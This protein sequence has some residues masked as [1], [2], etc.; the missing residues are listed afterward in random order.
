MIVQL[1]N[2]IAQHAPDL[3]KLLNDN[4]ALKAMTTA[5]DGKIYTVCDAPMFVNSMVVQNA[6]FIRQDWLDNLGLPVPVTLDDW[7]RVLTAFKNNDPTRT[8]RRDVVPYAGISRVGNLDNLMAFGSAF[9]LPV[10]D[11]EWWYDSSGRVFHV[12]SSP[13]YREF[14]TVMNQWYKDGLLD[15]E[16]NREEPNFQSLTSTNVVGAF[17]HLSERTTQYD[18]FVRSG[19][20]GTAKHILVPPPTAPNGANPQILKR[21]PTW[22]HYGITRDCKDPA[23]AMKWINFV[24][25]SDEGVLMNEYGV[26]GLSFTRGPDGKPRFTDFV[27]RNPNGLDPYNALRSLGACNTIL[28]RTPAQAYIDLNEGTDAIPFGQRLL[29]YR[30]EPFPEVMLSA[31][32]QRVVDRLQPDIKT[33]HDETRVKFLIGEIPLSNWD[34]YVQT[35]RSMGLDDVQ[36]VRQQQYNRGK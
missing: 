8:G 9:G 14:L 20:V 32:E 24:Y 21:P 22:S 11:T 26:E 17:V 23:L 19:G 4:P 31:D 3:Q 30:V 1:D 6:L 10:G 34:S 15:V 13:Q 29:P 16:L 18:G 28:V 7:H 25:G 33:Y 2:L 27:L 12:Y 35:L 5:P 36:R